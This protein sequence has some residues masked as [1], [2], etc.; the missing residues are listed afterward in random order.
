MAFRALPLMGFSQI[1]AGC[2]SAS[3]LARQ[4]ILAEVPTKQ[5]ALKEPQGLKPK[6]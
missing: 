2:A 6:K 1:A 3:P 5:R 4:I